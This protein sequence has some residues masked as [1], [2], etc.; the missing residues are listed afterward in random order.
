METRWEKV[1]L[2]L[3]A[4]LFSSAFYAA[5]ILAHLWTGGAHLLGIK[6]L[7]GLAVIAASMLQ[8]LARLLLLAAPGTLWG[9]AALLLDVLGFAL[10]LTHK[11]PL[12]R[13]L[14]AALHLGAALVSLP[15][16]RVLA[17]HLERADLAVWV[18]RLAVLILTTAG[19]LGVAAL[20]LEKPGLYLAALAFGLATV[21]YLRLVNALGGEVSKDLRLWRNMD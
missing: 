9:V 19:G 11:E 12:Y 4:L 14:G 2:G 18:N 20:G 1:Q 17:F 15:Q 21:R 8:V 16:L 5:L 3:H 6:G 13:G 10:V 7:A